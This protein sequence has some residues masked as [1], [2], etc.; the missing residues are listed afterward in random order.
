MELATAKERAIATLDSVDQCAK[1]AVWRY[2]QVV[3]SALKIKRQEIALQESSLC[4]A[5][6][7]T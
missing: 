6:H 7:V 2:H 5:M 1:E 3:S 4:D